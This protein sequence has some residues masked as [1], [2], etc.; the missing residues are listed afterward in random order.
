MGKALSKGTLSIGAEALLSAVSADLDS[1]HRRSPTTFAGSADVHLGLS[2]DPSIKPNVPVWISP[3]GYP[4]VC[5]NSSTPAAFARASEWLSYCVEHD[6]YCKPPNPKDFWPRRLVNVNLGDEAKDP[7]LVEPTEPMTYACLS[8]CWGPN[9]DKVLRTTKDNIEE[10]FSAIPFDRIPKSVQDAVK[11]CRR[12]N[13]PYLWVDSLCILQHDDNEWFVASAEM[14]R[15]YFN[16]HLTIAALEPASCESGFLGQQDFSTPGRRPDFEKLKSGNQWIEGDFSLN[17]R[18]WCLQEEI[19]PNRRLCFNGAEMSWECLCRKICECGHQLWPSRN[20]RNLSDEFNFAEL[21][22]FLKNQNLTVTLKQR[23]KAENALDGGPDRKLLWLLGTHYD[24]YAS[25]TM[26]KT[27]EV[28]R[29]LVTRYSRRTL[30]YRRDKLAAV[31]G[32]AGM[33]LHALYR[34]T[35]YREDNCEEY[36]AG[37]WKKELHFDLAW[38]IDIPVARLP[39]PVDRDDVHG[40]S[41]APSWS[42]ASSDTPVLYSCTRSYWGWSETPRVWERCEVIETECHYSRYRCM[43]LC[44]WNK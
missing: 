18:G 19:L 4:Q 5:E 12:L 37:L 7:F 26:S 31:A 25:T 16:S 2:G 41:C 1:T 21:G 20:R 35:L 10:H 14:D 40:A 6:G 23:A 42:W 29:Q 36:L 11:V 9:A 24:Q 30:S 38:Y 13:I 43:H 28:W 33:T 17:S 44:G 32:L 15:T 39:D 3:H 22:G 34:E 27:R 8:Y